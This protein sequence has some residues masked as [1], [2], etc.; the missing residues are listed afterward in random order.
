[1]IIKAKIVSIKLHSFVKDAEIELVA[2]NVAIDRELG[3]RLMVVF[4]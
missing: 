4:K 3:Q 2:I 1:M